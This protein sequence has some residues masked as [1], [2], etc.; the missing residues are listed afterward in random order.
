MNA[1]TLLLLCSA[2]MLAACSTGAPRVVTQLK[3]V[4]CPNSLVELDCAD[5]TPARSIETAY[6][7]QRA[8]VRCVVRLE[9]RD[10]WIR[11]TQTVHA[12]CVKE[13]AP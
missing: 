10:R 8:Y 4:A 11:Q 5:C 6:D 7:L 2:L 13:T 9:C 12:E 3:T 1:R